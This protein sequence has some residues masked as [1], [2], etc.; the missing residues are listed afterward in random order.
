[1]AFFLNNAGP[2][3]M[4][5]LWLSYLLLN[6]GISV[7]LYAP[8]FPIVHKDVT[9]DDII[10]LIPY[11]DGI[12]VNKLGVTLLRT[13]RLISGFLR[14]SFREKERVLEIKAFNSG[15]G[16]Q[17]EVRKDL[18]REAGNY[19]AVIL[20]G[21]L[22]YGYF[23]GL[24]KVLN[25]PVSYYYDCDNSFKMESL[26]KMGWK[27]A[28][29]NS[30]KNLEEEVKPII[31]KEYLADTHIFA[32][33]THKNPRQ[34]LDIWEEKSGKF[35][36]D[37]FD[38][39]GN[40]FQFFPAADY[41]GDSYN[42]WRKV[43][44]VYKIDG[45]D[46]LNY[47]EEG[48]REKARMACGFY[49]N[50]KDFKYEVELIKKEKE[51]HSYLYKTPNKRILISIKK[52]A[53]NYLMLIEFIIN[54]GNLKKFSEKEKQGIRS[55]YYIRKEEWPLLSSKIPSLIA[56]HLQRSIEGKGEINDLSRKRHNPRTD[57]QADN[58][59]YLS[60][61]KNSDITF[62]QKVESVDPKAGKQLVRITFN[63][64]PEITL[65]EGDVYLLQLR[66]HLRIVPG[67]KR[68]EGNGT[69]EKRSYISLYVP[70][71][72][73]NETKKLISYVPNV[74]LDEN[75]LEVLRVLKLEQN[76][77]QVK[78]C[79]IFPKDEKDF[80]KIDNRPG[81]T[82]D[83]IYTV[84]PAPIDIDTPVAERM[85]VRKLLDEIQENY[86]KKFI[87]YSEMVRLGNIFER[88]DDPGWWEDYDYMTGLPRMN[89]HS[90]EYVL[91]QLAAPHDTT[92]DN[93][94][95]DANGDRDWE[96]ISR[97]FAVAAELA[98]LNGAVGVDL[99]FGSPAVANQGGGARFSDNEKAREKAIEI[100][101]TINERL[102]GRF[103]KN[104][105][106]PGFPF[107]T[108]KI[109]LC[110][111]EEN[112]KKPDWDK[113]KEFII[114]LFQHVDWVVLHLRTKEQEYSGYCE[115]Y[116]KK[117]E[118]ASLKINDKKGKKLFY[119]GDLFSMEEVEK[120]KNF[121]EFDGVFDGIM[122]ARGM[123][124]NPFLVVDAIKYIEYKRKHRTE[125]GLERIK[126][127]LELHLEY[128]EANLGY[129]FLPERFKAS[130][131]KYAKLIVNR[132]NDK[133]RDSLY[134]MLEPMKRI[135]EEMYTTELKRI[136]KPR[137]FITDRCRKCRSCM[138]KT[139]CD[140]I[141]EERG[142]I[143]I[144]EKKC[145]SCGRCYKVCPYNAIELTN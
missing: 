21:E 102:V 53:K 89:I 133:E 23:C 124:G 111:I 128:K 18:L 86:D 6:A 122:I 19:N 96:K 10:A 119:N 3:T 44:K 57:Y 27:E 9:I 130:L 141:I 135:S 33:L 85:V 75:R 137:F 72:C 50:L 5:A 30:I 82:V 59:I 92:S 126:R 101:R 52:I 29:G 24:G 64:K 90:E 144:D 134:K 20:I 49:F 78:I 60:L 2:E 131:N 65:N 142:L 108:A 51:N 36:H 14:K 100:C 95:N 129:S 31:D 47:N 115:D 4:F 28:L 67:N 66:K 54:F 16:E 48:F 112:S 120:F 69:E 41:R 32:I 114:G 140:K 121:E 98:I 35:A 81:I 113:T 117:H 91:I 45:I 110:P 76:Q 25:H 74:S 12:L 8:T 56:K 109:R 15:F 118:V 83:N 80:W 145:L 93:I 88:N 22:W 1:V 143:R 61:K 116:F 40:V 70:A 104:V 58:F 105:T 97:Y 77:D 26:E 62:E 94:F 127:A 71:F 13:R 38:T 132:L 34:R 123:Q 39:G 107:L 106:T 125:W 84:L 103:K 138:V 136:I 73:D 68:K 99:N 63:F 79:T 55:N 46:E 17:S 87:S 139:R 37:V 11:F 43:L 7:S 42:G